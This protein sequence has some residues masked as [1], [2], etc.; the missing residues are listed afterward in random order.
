MLGMGLVFQTP[1]VTY[2]LSRIG[3][4]TASYLVR[5]WRVSLVVIM[6][7][8]AVLSPTGD[9]PLTALTDPARRVYGVSL[10]LPD[11]EAAFG[12][13]PALAGLPNRSADN[14]GHQ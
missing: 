11:L 4:A 6:A 9:C 14:L 8:A 1:A 12:R 3:L 7:A 2:V 10:G 13:R 5:V